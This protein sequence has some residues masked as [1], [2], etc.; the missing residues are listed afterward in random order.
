MPARRMKCD[1]CRNYFMASRSDSKWCSQKCR[2]Q[3][4]MENAKFEVSE[5]PRSGVVGVTFSRIRK[6][7]QVAIPEDG[8]MKY[9]GSVGTL[10]DAI[11]LQGEILGHEVQTSQDV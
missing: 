6:R 11:K 3:N 9:V 8:R 1:Q 2:Y 4:R 10:Q 7:W 5:I